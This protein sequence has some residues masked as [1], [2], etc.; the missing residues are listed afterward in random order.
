MMQKA[1]KLFSLIM[2][3]Q[4]SSTLKLNQLLQTMTSHLAAMKKHEIMLEKIARESKMVVTIFHEKSFFFY[5]SPS[6]LFFLFLQPDLPVPILPTCLNPGLTAHELTRLEL[7]H[8]C[9][10]GPP[11][12]VAIFAKE[13]ESSKRSSRSDSSVTTVCL[14][15]TRVLNDSF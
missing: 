1:R 3:R 9:F 6:Q 7:D 4:K 15:R 10:L 2:E 8:L 5:A 11:E 13:S 12:L 14:L